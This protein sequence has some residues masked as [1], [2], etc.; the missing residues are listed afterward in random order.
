LTKAREH[1]WQ[2]DGAKEQKERANVLHL[3]RKHEWSER[4][5]AKQVFGKETSKNKVH[6]ILGDGGPIRSDLLNCPKCKNAGQ[7]E[8]P[9]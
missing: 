3:H 8:R 5:I 6:R 7:S 1:R 2:H 9:T 4:R